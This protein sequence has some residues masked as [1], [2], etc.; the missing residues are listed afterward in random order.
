M[1]L[2]QGEPGAI[3]GVSSGKTDAGELR[4]GFQVASSLG[5]LV[6]PEETDVA[7]NDHNQMK[8]D[9]DIAWK[10]REAMLQK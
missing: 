10:E 7:W 1:S 6:E 8:E 5:E 4:D 9:E 3:R 2:E